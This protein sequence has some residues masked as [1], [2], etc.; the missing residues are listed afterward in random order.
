MSDLER[1]LYQDEVSDSD[2]RRFLD[3][4]TDWYFRPKSFEKWENGKVYETL[5]IKHLK[6]LC[7]ET[8]R[9]LVKRSTGSDR[10]SFKNNYLIWN[11]SKEG[12]KKFD[13]QTRMNEAIHILPTAIF[14]GLT[15]NYLSEG[16]YGM[17]ALETGLNLALGIGPLLLQRYNRA[18][19]HNVIDRMEAKEKM[20]T[21]YQ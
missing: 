14:S 21:P 2:N 6:K 16:K 3:R 1:E 13:Y 15:A 7:A 4:M 5:G 20:S 9:K 12:L 17:A 19:L 18:R 10:A 11:F 8:Y